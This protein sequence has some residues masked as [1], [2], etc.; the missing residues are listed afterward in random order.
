MPP[1]IDREMYKVIMAID[2]N[3]LKN[4]YEECGLTRF[5][6]QAAMSRAEALKSAAQRLIKQGRVIDP[7]RWVEVSTAEGSR[8]TIRN[9][10][11][12]RHSYRCKCC[13]RG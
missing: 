4:M 5:E 9:F 11:A 3:E 10:Y 7:N 2:L 1:V 13:R 8:C 6:I 12:A